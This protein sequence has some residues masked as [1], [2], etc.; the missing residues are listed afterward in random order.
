MFMLDTCMLSAQPACLPLPL[1]DLL[2]LS[3]SPPPSPIRCPS[4]V[5]STWG[6][7]LWNGICLAGAPEVGHGVRRSLQALS[8][9]RS[10]QVQGGGRAV[11]V[12]VQLYQQ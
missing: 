10:T 3:T 8:S 2:V 6:D 12:A 5:Y 9:S 11:S 7:R 4:G 1:L